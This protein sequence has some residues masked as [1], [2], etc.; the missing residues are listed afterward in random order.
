MPDVAEFP[1]PL[2]FVL[3]GGGAIGTPDIIVVQRRQGRQLAVAEAM[4]AVMVERQMAVAPFHTGTAALE[5]IG[6]A[7][8]RCLDV[9]PARGSQGL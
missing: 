3:S 7:G 4:T 6:T 1:R 8:G 2:A 9:R 5:Q